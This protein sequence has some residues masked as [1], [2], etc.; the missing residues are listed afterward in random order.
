M[1]AERTRDNLLDARDFAGLPY[2]TPKQSL[3]TKASEEAWTAPM[4]ACYTYMMFHVGVATGKTR[5]IPITELVE[6][7]PYERAAV[8]KAIRALKKCGAVIP[9]KGKAHQYHLPHVATTEERRTLIRP[10][11]KAAAAQQSDVSAPA[12]AEKPAEL[13]PE[14]PAMGAVE[15]GR[16]GTSVG[17][18]MSMNGNAAHET[19]PVIKVLEEWRSGEQDE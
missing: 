12:P 1:T 4:W 2:S 8:Y 6:V 9:L 11:P 15:R 18:R 3:F 17:T 10:K 16:A 14:T 5:A 13:P 19:R 7:T